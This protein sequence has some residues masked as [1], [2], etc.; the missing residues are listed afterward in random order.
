METKVSRRGQT[1]IA[2]EIRRRHGIVAGQRLAWL[3]D[4]RTITVVPVPADPVR[5]LRG[6][7]RGE[8][9]GEKLLRDRQED[10]RRDR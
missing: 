10:R 7:G 2:A 8:G 4:G 3:D 9:L 5:E 1:V 6:R